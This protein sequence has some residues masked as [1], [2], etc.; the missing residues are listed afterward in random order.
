[1][2][3]PVLQLASPAAVAAT[4]ALFALFLSA[5]AFV[6]ARNVLGD[7]KPVKALGVGPGPAVLATLPPTFGVNPFLALGAAILVDAAAFYL[8]FE[9]S[10][11]LVAYITLI[12]VVVSI[13][14]GAIVF[15]LLAI[16]SSAP[17]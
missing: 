2:A 15:G 4:V 6:A 5:T 16:I 9:R 11:R 3:A 12:H 7:V 8:L 14:A 13:I 1:V 17:I 10:P